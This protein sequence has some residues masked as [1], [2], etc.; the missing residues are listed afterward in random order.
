MKRTSLLMYTSSIIALL[1]ALPIH[2]QEPEAPLSFPVY[3][4]EEFSAVAVPA[5][6]KTQSLK[7]KARALRKAKK[8]KKT[9]KSPF[10]ATWST[11]LKQQQ[12]TCAPGLPAA[13]N[14]AIKINEKLVAT[15]LYDGSPFFTGRI[16][17]ADRIGFARQKQ[18]NGYK[19]TQTLVL[20]SVKGDKGFTVLKSETSNGVQSCFTIYS[21]NSKASRK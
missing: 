19:I 10:V 13:I 18:S 5:S 21:G 17:A 9:Q 11:L 7:I 8:D 4:S 15:D 1:V 12:N 16:L 6:I 3:S 2:A 20:G 14:V